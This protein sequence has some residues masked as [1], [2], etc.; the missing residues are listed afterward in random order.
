MPT[1][2]SVAVTVTPV[3]GA[4]GVG[5]KAP[6]QSTWMRDAAF[7]EN[8]INSGQQDGG[9]ALSGSLKAGATF[10]A[11]LTRTGVEGNAIFINNVTALLNGNTTDHGIVYTAASGVK[12]ISWRLPERITLPILDKVVSEQKPDYDG[13]FAYTTNDQNTQALSAKDTP[14]IQPPP[15]L[16]GFDVTKVANVYIDL[17]FNLYLVWRYPDETLYTL[18]RT[19]LETTFAASIGPTGFLK[20]DDE[21][22][23]RAQ[24]NPQYEVTHTNDYKR[25]NKIFN[26]AVRWVID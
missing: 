24:A 17:W 15:D 4:F 5:P 16:G 18:A 20:L 6:P 23:V 7:T 1:T 3:I 14:Y 2:A 9:G 10:G 19:W 25:S 13:D 21:S 22:L 11:T 26:R 12:P 8:G